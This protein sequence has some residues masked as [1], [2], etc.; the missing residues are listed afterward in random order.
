[1]PRA[2]PVAGLAGAVGVV[3]LLTSLLHGVEPIDP[4]TF[5]IAPVLLVAVAVTASLLPAYRATGVDPMHAMR[6][7]H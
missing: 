5:A 4:A 7:D 1:V 2:G 3:R 6:T